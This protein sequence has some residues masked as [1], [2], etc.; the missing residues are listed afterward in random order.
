MGPYPST[1]REIKFCRCLFTSSIKREIMHFH[2]VVVQKSVMHVQSCCFA[3][4]TYCFCL[5][6]RFLPRLW[7]VRIVTV[8]CCEVA[9]V[10]LQF[11]CA[12]SDSTTFLRGVWKRWNPESGI[13][14]RSPEPESETETEPEP[15][16]KK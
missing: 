13:R 8:V 7:K 16:P 2:V 12:R 10:A 1:E 5:R 15:E 14:N 9:A 4:K 11:S 6:S 3:Y